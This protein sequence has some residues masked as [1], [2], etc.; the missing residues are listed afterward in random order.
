MSISKGIII[1]LIKNEK[2]TDFPGNFNLEK[3]KA[4]RMLVVVVQHT[5][6]II[7][8]TELKKYLP[9][10]AIENAFL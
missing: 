8:T 4:A 6:P 9:K 5:E 7:T 2:I 10:G 1:R 3:A